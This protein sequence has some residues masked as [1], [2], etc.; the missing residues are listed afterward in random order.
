MASGLAHPWGLGFAGDAVLF[1]ERAGSIKLL[2]NG[3]V[4]TV[5]VDLGDVRARGEGG[6]LDLAL[7]PDFS[8]DRLGY[9]CFASTAGDVRVVKMTFAADLASAQRAPGPVLTGIPLNPSGRHSGCRLHIDDEAMLW[10]STGDAANGT[11]PQDLTSLGGKVLRLNPLNG[12][13]ATDNPYLGTDDERTRLVFSY[14]HRNPQGLAEQ[15]GTGRMFSVEHGSWR[16]D[17]VNVLKAGGNYGWNPVGSS[18]YDESVPMTDQQLSGTVVPAIWSSGRP[19]LA[20]S[21]ATFLSGSQW[22]ALEGDLVVAALKAQRLM[23]FSVRDGRVVDSSD[24]P[25][26][27]NTYG[28]LRTV[29]Q[30]PDG[31]LWV[32]TSNGSDDALLRVRPRS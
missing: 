27:T 15:P 17:E 19:T 12:E 16:D 13:P 4:S 21:G 2:R 1:T 30:A 29:Q 24:V 25:G 32:A 22:G 6:L 8:E 9:V 14:G 28:R 18:S 26:F 10:V 31:A 5:R 20:T 11:N 7:S 3:S 23:A